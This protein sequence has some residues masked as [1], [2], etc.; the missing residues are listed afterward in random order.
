MEIVL[1]FFNPASINQRRVTG[2]E[3]V[4]TSLSRVLEHSKKSN[5]GGITA[6]R[7]E[8]TLK[9]NRELNK[10]LEKQIRKAGFG[11]TKVRGRYVE[12]K[13]SENQQNVD[14]ESFIIFA[15]PEQKDALFSFL[16]KA[17]K[18][19]TQDSVLF[20]AHDEPTAKLHNTAGANEGE[21]WDVG[22]FSAKAISEFLSIL[23]ESNKEGKERTKAF[24]FRPKKGV[25]KKADKKSERKRAKNAL[26]GVGK[27]TSHAETKW[28]ESLSKKEQEAYLKEHPNSKRKV[29]KS[30]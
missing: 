14:E 16:K 15:E 27:K 18:K 13:G 30:K 23:K 11:F 28:W 5:V 22:E 10:E 7:G 24:E 19:F 2:E 25:E 20:K 1:S 17:G 6:F 3:V 4:A 12:N 26:L 8:N 21:V 29:T 9:K